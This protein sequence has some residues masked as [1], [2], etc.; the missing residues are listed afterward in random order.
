MSENH[1]IILHQYP[2]SLFS[3]KIRLLLGYKQASYAMVEIPIIMPKPD[4]MPLTGGYRKT[5]VMQIGADIY[6][7][8]ALISRV[9][10]DIYP[11]NSIYPEQRTSVDQ[12]FAHWTDTFFFRVCVAIAFSPRAAASNPLFQDQNAI[13]A[14][15]A[16]R[17]EL[18]KGSS[19]LQ[20]TFE[21][22][23]PHFLA[24]LNHLD[25]ELGSDKPYLGGELPTIADFS[26]YHNIWF[27]YTREVLRDY[28]DPFPNLVAWYKR[29]LEFGHGDF[30]MIEG[31]MALKQ[32]QAASPD[33]VD[34]GTFLG[35]LTSG[36]EV[37]VM[38]ID[39][40][41]QP[42]RG[43]LLSAGLDEI[44]IARTDEQVGRVVVHFP[45]IGFQV[46]PVS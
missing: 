3:E 17:A 23:E 20:M 2:E 45:R 8:T 6:C 15:M 43:E 24:H 19:E 27:I 13:A 28:F 46:N 18:S 7:D 26:T 16:D 9:I 33:E 32:A 40:G 44:A 42:V 5:P 14:F 36:Q 31:Q 21:I 39:Y 25:T 1:Q 22:A 29:M 11:D 30:E 12:A 37:D 10:D 38:P 4:L 35:G 34:E 41:F